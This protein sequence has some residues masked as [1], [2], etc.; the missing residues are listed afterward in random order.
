MADDPATA[1]KNGVDALINRAVSQMNNERLPWRARTE[2]A[3]HDLRSAA[4]L[5]DLLSYEVP[6]G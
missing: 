4:D 3:A 2:S 1:L 6:R 5:M